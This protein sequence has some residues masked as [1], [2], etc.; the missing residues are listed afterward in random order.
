MRRQPLRQLPIYSAGDLLRREKPG[1]FNPF[2]ES[3][4]PV[5][6]AESW[7]NVSRLVSRE[8]RIG[9]FVNLV[10]ERRFASR[11]DSS[12]FDLTVVRRSSESAGSS[13]RI[14]LGGLRLVL[15]FPRSFSRNGILG[16]NLPRGLRSP[17]LSSRRVYFRC[18][19]DVWKH[20]TSSSRDDKRR[21]WTSNIPREDGIRSKSPEP[22][23]YNG[24]KRRNKG[25]Y[26]PL[27]DTPE[28]ID[29]MAE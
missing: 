3:A 11:R 1:L 26:C 28:I 18:Q 14:I 24:W 23:G 29:G 21:M 6:P 19:I 8:S 15:V 7:S 13:L 9:R 5:C 12:Q 25:W 2:P 16:R 20:V 22:S 10:L 17:R 4:N 27:S